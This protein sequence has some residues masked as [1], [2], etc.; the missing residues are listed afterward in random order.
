MFRGM[1]D[2]QFQVIILVLGVLIFLELVGIGIFL[3][4]R[5]RREKVS[6]ISPNKLEKLSREY[7]EFYLQFRTERG[8]ASNIPIRIFDLRT[9]EEYLKGHIKHASLVAPGGLARLASRQKFR[10]KTVIL[11]TD[12]GKTEE[13]LGLARALGDGGA[14]AVY[15]YP[16]FSPN[17]FSEAIIQRAEIP[18]G[19]SPSGS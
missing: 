3:G 5:N 19:T 15:I 12:S 8:L 6:Y 11:Y 18:P 10:G 13:L 4:R 17:V 16:N 2:R 9:E 1:T 7:L 14:K